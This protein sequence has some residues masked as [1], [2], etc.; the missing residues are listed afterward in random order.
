MIG[1]T[2]SHYRV[3]SE[4]GR[5]GMGVVYE[6]EDSKLG[7]RVALKFLPKELASDPQVLERF[8]FEARAASALN[9]ENIC[10]IFEIDEA[11]GQPF[12]SMELLKGQSLAERLTRAL[13]LDQVLEIAVQVSDALDAAHHAGFVH[14]DIKPANIFITDRG[15]VKVLDFGLAKLARERREAA[16]M[17]GVTVDD[18]HAPL[19]VTSPGSTVGT[20][21]YMSPE[22]AR[23][24]ELDG[25]SDLFSFGAVLYQMATGALPFDGNTPAVVFHAILATDPAVPSKLQPNLPPKLDEIILKA[26]EKDRDMRYQSAAEMRADLKRLRRDS[27]SGR[28]QTATWP[29]ANTADAR[30]ESLLSGVAIGEQRAASSAKIKAK[31]NKTA[32]AVILALLALCVGVGLWF[33]IATLTKAKPAINTQTMAIRPMTDNSRVIQSVISPD[34]KWLAYVMREQERS[35]W[36]K[37]IAT[38]SEF[39]VLKAQ[40]GVFGDIVFSPDGNYIYYSHTPDATGTLYDLYRVP[41]LGGATQRIMENVPWTI[42]FSPDGKQVAFVRPNLT[43]GQF[44]VTIS[45]PDGSGQHVIMTRPRGIGA[46]RSAPTWGANN[47]IALAT[48]K[49]APN[50]ISEILVFTPEGQQVAAI[51]SPLVINAMNWMP[52]GS[53]LMISGQGKEPGQQQ[54]QL[55]WQPYPSGEAVRITNDLNDY[56]RPSIAADGKTFVASMSRPAGMVYVGPAP[57]QLGPQVAWNLKPITTEQ[58]NAGY[59]SW[60]GAGNLLVVEG[61]GTVMMSPDGSN[62]VRLY[63]EAKIVGNPV[64]CGPGN[65]AVVW[66]IGESND[67]GLWYVDPSSGSVRRVTPENQP[68]DTG[69]CTADG[70]T[71]IYYRH[72]APEDELY[73][74]SMA[75]GDP[76]F[77]AR[78][79]FS[80][81]PALSPDGTLIA[82]LQ[83]KRAEN[84]L[85]V[86][87][88]LRRFA[89]GSIVKELS[90]PSR[91]DGTLNWTPDG[92]AVTYVTMV[93]SIENIYMQPIDGSVPVQ[94]T[95]FDWE[96]ATIPGYGWSRDGKQ[97]A[98]THRRLNNA[99][100]MMFSNY[101]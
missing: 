3:V 83:Y 18:K 12:I 79:V 77:I 16:A 5:G 47:L 73:R 28:V 44:E 91:T 27:S 17:A 53:G 74:K 99:D 101:R 19:L 96:P 34:G 8:R 13:P 38:G 23:G 87:I 56:G 50:V 54:Y 85:Q 42:T 30:L 97:F 33:L 32:A 76:Q 2:I 100:V 10:T 7:R 66:S 31:R 93:G 40:P 20:I 81:W 46:P 57:G 29:A 35:L 64:S 21:A 92:K 95:H 6:A 9:H 70:V 37:Q 61:A 84:R 82:S 68:V 39:Q 36:V 45:A 26:L 59:L 25:R 51:E 49:L 14:R 4:L 98:Y 15:R 75:G 11:D 88:V 71:L 62:R 69:V 1:E 90:V 60:T 78:G 67:L 22:Q 94:L 43:T 58:A 65:T 52:D 86:E 41:S 48:A 63:P 80:G 24:E 89:D 72:N 55:V